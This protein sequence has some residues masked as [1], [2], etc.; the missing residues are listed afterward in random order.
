MI[1]VG[2]GVTA[3]VIKVKRLEEVCTRADAFVQPAVKRKRITFG[4]AVVRPIVPIQM[5]RPPK[6][7]LIMLEDFDFE[8]PKPL[9]NE[10][11]KNFVPGDAFARVDMLIMEVLEEAHR[12]ALIAYLGLRKQHKLFSE[13]IGMGSVLINF[14]DLLRKTSAQL[15]HLVSSINSEKLLPQKLLSSLKFDFK[16]RMTSLE[17]SVKYMRQSH[18]ELVNKQWRQHFDLLRRGDKLRADLSLEITANRLMQQKQSG[19]INSSLAYLRSQLAE[20]VAHLKR[21]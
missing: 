18:M 17:L 19:A 12:T 20:V 4:K 9:P 8:D 3:E 14:V 10:I 15:Q 2:S 11:K 13:A 6:H 1:F 21:A 7:K 5:M 16:E